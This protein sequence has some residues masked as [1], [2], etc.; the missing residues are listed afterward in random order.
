[1]TFIDNAG[2]QHN[3]KNNA[4][5]Q[6]CFRFLGDLVCPFHV[7]RVLVM[8]I[9]SG[10]NGRSAN[11]QKQWAIQPF[12]SSRYIKTLLFNLQ[13]IRVKN[14]LFLRNLLSLK[15]NVY[16][17]SLR[18]CN[19]RKKLQKALIKFHFAVLVIVL[20][21]ILFEALTKYSL[22]DHLELAMAV[23]VALSG[24]MLFFFC[25]RPFKKIAF[26]FSM[27]VLLMILAVLAWIF[28]SFFFGVILVILLYPIFPGEKSTNRKV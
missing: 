21:N 12:L 5:T 19:M 8:S 2:N 4:Q 10:V 23:V 24:G 9:E 26:Y 28:R 25:L 17:L 16:N 3:E 11:W 7:S 6:R 15:G 14:L 27:Y 20:L 22:D 1:M 18:A 13:K